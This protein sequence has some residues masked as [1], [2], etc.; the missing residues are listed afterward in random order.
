MKKGLTKDEVL[1]I[2][3]FGRINN[4]S[5]QQACLSLGFPRYTCITEYKKKYGIFEDINVNPTGYKKRKYNVNDYFFE[6]PNILNSYY[7][8]FIAAD[9]NV[10]SRKSEQ[11]TIKIELSSKDKD[12]IE[13]FKKDIL[14]ESP[15]KDR[16][17]KER[18]STSG[19]SI[20]S[21]KIV[22][23][24]KR[25][26]NITPQKSLTL[27]PP[28]LK[29]NNKFAFICGYIDGDGCVF[30]SDRGKIN[31]VLIISILGTMEMC[32]WIKKTFDKITNNCG[33]IKKKPNTK[34]FCLSYSCKGAREIAKIIYELNVPKLQRKWTNEIREH[35]EKYVKGHNHTTKN[36]YVFTS[37][38]KF[39]KKC[40]SLKEASAFTKVNYTLISHI[41]CN[42]IYKQ[43]NGYTFRRTNIF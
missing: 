2:I 4:V 26:F 37:E 39:I 3:N 12:W 8:G 15:I 1:S 31:K 19:I 29:G 20:T 35:V 32:E 30:L 43:S 18:F 9:G 22:N 42:N 24:L 28:N 17:Q 5:I 40:K 13:N 25:N 21:E 11:R 10:C 36:V 23:D 7:A 41:L 16:V 34:I 38:G 27:L 14:S 33:K 6:K